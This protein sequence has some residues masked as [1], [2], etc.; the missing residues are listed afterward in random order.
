MYYINLWGEGGGLEL[1]SL[2]G[3]TWREDYFEDLG[4][5]GRIILKWIW[6]W[7]GGMDLIDLAQE[8]GRLCNSDNE[9]LDFVKGWEFFD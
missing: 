2:G 1:H 5:D 4:V 8:G 3:E 6:N 9:H 7:L